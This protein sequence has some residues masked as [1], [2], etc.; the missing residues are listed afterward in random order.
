MGFNPCIQVFKDKK[1]SQMEKKYH[2]GLYNSSRKGQYWI[3]MQRSD[4]SYL[5][6][7][8]GDSC[9]SLQGWIGKLL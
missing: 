8:G 5:R 3:L 7:F 9:G 2:N 4:S 6:K 1:I